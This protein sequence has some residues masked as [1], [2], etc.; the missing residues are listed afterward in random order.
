MKVRLKIGMLAI[1]VLTCSPLVLHEAAACP[2]LQLDIAGGSYD[3]ATETIVSGGSEFSLY[4]LMAPDKQY[5]NLSSYYYIAAALTPN[6]DASIDPS[7]KSSTDLSK[8]THPDLGSFTFNGLEVQVTKDMVY[9]TPP[10]ETYATQLFDSGDLS[11]HSIYNTYFIQFVFQFD[12]ANKTGEYN[13]ALTP[14][15][16]PVI[17]SDGSMYFEEFLVDVSNLNPDYEIHFDLYNTLSIPTYTTTTSQVCTKRNRS[18]AC[19]RWK[20]VCANVTLGYD[21]DIATFAPFSKDAESTH[22]V[23][24]PGTMLLLGS[25]LLGLG[26]LR[27]RHNA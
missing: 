16:T 27:R 2:S 14:G 15:Q 11:K 13:S 12:A 21:I 19:T 10:L 23:P 5:A 8:L 26:L 22:T 18:G 4:A 6:P 3:T 9:G 20:T 7:I 25:A 1:L 17:T 24:E